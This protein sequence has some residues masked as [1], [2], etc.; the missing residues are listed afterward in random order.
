LRTEILER[1]VERVSQFRAAAP[2]RASSIPPLAWVSGAV[3]DNAKF[4]PR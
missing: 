1:P 2:P 4:V 3:I